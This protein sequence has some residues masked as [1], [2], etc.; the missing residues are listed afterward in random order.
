MNRQ[1]GYDH[2]AHWLID[3]LQ[4]SCAHQARIL[5]LLV[6][7]A[8]RGVAPI[9]PSPVLAHVAPE[10]RAAR[11]SMVGDPN[12]AIFAFAGARVETM[13]EFPTTYPG[14][15]VVNLGQSYRSTPNVLVVADRLIRHNGRRLG[16]RVWT[17]NA[18][19]D[20][21][22]VMIH[23]TDED[24]ATALAARAVQLATEGSVAI[25]ARSRR[26]DRSRFRAMQ[27]N[28]VLRPY[29]ARSLRMRPSATRQAP[30]EAL[31][32]PCRSP[33]SRML[34]RRSAIAARLSRPSSTILMGGMRTP[35]W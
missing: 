12:Q 19:G 30:S 28:T 35:S 24:E 21:V 17:A 4:D 26:S 16:H 34:F 23:A 1:W 27:S 13:L 14:G 9:V 32:S 18:P 3:E 15:H 8:P 6:R 25:L 10:I 31:K 2:V 33:G 5:E 29:F 20:D 11:A 22:E 7:P